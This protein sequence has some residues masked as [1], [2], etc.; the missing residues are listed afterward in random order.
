MKRGINLD[1][2]TTWP[3]E[4]RWDEPDVDPALSG[5]AQEP[6]R[7]DLAALKAAGFDFVRMP[8][9]PSPF[10]SD[11]AAGLRDRLV[12]SVVESARLINEAGLKVVVDMHLFP[13]GGSRS[14][15]MGEVMDDPEMF[16]R[17][18]EL[19]RTMAHALVERGPGAGRLRADER[20]GR[21]LRRTITPICGPIAC[22]GSTPRRAP[23]RRG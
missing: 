20:A 5:M 11:R 7:N 3:P 19:V 6:G 9:D 16:D 2:W 10:L 1:I 21:R 22:S 18:V 13:A 15:G 14:V 12:A 23:R 8:V 4:D 17:Y